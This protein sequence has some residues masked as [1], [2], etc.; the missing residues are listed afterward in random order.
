MEDKSTP[1]ETHLI[2]SFEIAVES[3]S[4][5]II[6]ACR[7]CGLSYL[8]KIDNYNQIGS[9]QAIPHQNVQGMSPYNKALEDCNKPTW[10]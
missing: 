2:H 9:W 8:L 5:I 10:E 6:Q 1:I 7:L 3:K 4:G